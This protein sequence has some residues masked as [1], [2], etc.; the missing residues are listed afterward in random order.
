VTLSLVCF[1]VDRKENNP[2]S[3]LVDGVE[4]GLN[5]TKS[6]TDSLTNW[7]CPEKKESLVEKIMRSDCRRNM[8]VR[9]FAKKNLD[10]D[11]YPIYFTDEGKC[12][13]LFWRRTNC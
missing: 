2:Q 11:T 6:E 1:E 5:K 7:I 13:Y 12:A 9:R 8:L 10:N 4:T 3:K